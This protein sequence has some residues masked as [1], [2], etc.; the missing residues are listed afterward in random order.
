MG[1][2]ASRDEPLLNE[3]FA[4]AERTTPARNLR[5]L[6]VERDRRWRFH[7]RPPNL[8]HVSS[9]TAASVVHALITYRA[10]LNA[11]RRRTFERYRPADVAF[12]LVGTGS[13]GTRDYVVLLFGNGVRDPLFMQVKQELP[14]CYAP[15]LAK[16]PGADHQGRRVAE[17]QQMMQTLS[18]PFLGYTRFGGHD[19]LVRQLADHKA[20]LDPTQLNRQTLIEYASLCGEALAKGHARTGDA[21][22]LAGYV[23][24][25]GK[26]DEAMTTFAR[27]YADQTKADYRMF[28]Q[29]HPM[30]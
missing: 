12:K 8:Q 13:V 5:K 30:R 10:T 20:A 11:S 23:G 16:V 19:Y 4:D 9:G 15:Y 28:K 22:L 26:L 17:G 27:A 21:A 25:S 18:D 7:D 3:I 2:E 29:S 6:T 24:K 1:P 14:S